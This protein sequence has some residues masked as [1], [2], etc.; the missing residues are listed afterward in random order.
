MQTKLLFQF[1]PLLA[2]TVLRRNGLDVMYITSLDENE[3]NYL[4]N[5]LSSAV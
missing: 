4:M 2:P 5:L 1:Q 3:G